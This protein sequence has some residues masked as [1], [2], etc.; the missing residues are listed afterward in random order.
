[1]III[2]VATTLLILLL[3]YL[4]CILGFVFNGFL[5]LTLRIRQL[6]MLRP[7]IKVA[8]LVYL[9]LVVSSVILICLIITMCGALCIDDQLV[10]FLQVPYQFLILLHSHIGISA[11]V[12]A[13]LT[14]PFLLI[15]LI[16]E[17]K[18]VHFVNLRLT[19]YLQSATLRSSDSQ[20]HLLLLPFNII[21]I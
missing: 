17:S 6:L 19:W 10:L 2:V 4:L 7:H 13:P 14:K 5:R 8:D 18:G 16:L 3:L 9:D 12:R 11:S 15:F 1:M 20:Y 21:F